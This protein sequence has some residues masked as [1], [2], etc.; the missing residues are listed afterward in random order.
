M[1]ALS[2]PKWGSK[3]CSSAAQLA[4]RGFHAAAAHGFHA[5][6]GRDRRHDGLRRVPIDG[7]RGACLFGTVAAALADGSTPDGLRATAAS[8][9]RRRPHA[10]VQFGAELRS[11]AELAALL[12][13]ELPLVY[14]SELA[15]GHVGRRARARGARQ[16]ARA[17]GAR[18]AAAFA[19]T[20]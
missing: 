3:W 10:I 13:A 15:R 5:A 2:N 19:W 11:V 4:A 16:P 7:S 17:A 18:A 12:A 9:V 8:L 1:P 20:A 14:A 6:R